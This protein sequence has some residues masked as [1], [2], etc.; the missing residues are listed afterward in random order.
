MWV[1]LFL[2]ELPAL[3]HWH[4]FNNILITVVC[5]VGFLGSLRL[6]RRMP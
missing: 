2:I 4:R 3:I 5:V 6:A 1:V